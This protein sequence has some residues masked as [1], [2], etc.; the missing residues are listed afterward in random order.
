MVVNVIIV[1]IDWITADS[2]SWY[3]PSSLWMVDGHLLFCEAYL[4]TLPFMLIFPFF[5][6]F[7]ALI[8]LTDKRAL[9][10]LQV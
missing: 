10:M 6:L 3:L 2:R 7:R 9:Q 8:S 5:R 1:C 4:L